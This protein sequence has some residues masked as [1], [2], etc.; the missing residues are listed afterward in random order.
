MSSV[1]Q[2]FSPVMS[3]VAQGFSPAMLLL[4]LVAVT[5]CAPKAK[6]TPPAVE[7]APAFR[8][9]ADWKTA[10]PADDQLR[11]NWW[12]LFGDADLNALEQQIDVSNQTLR[13]A[14]AQFEQARAVVR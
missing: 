6:Y 4:A 1:A 2:R 7:I 11:G 14:A 3:S 8:E 13:A 12:E 9:N 5:G 10:Q